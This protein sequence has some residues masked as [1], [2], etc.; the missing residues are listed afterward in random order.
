MYANWKTKLCRV[1][2]YF[3]GTGQVIVGF[4]KPLGW[5]R[6]RGLTLCTY[7]QCTILYYGVKTVI[8]R[9]LRERDRNTSYNMFIGVAV[10]AIRLQCRV[11]I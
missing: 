2:T 1:D 4:R 5:T 7:V 3:I 6:A 10:H 11:E 9:R 8:N